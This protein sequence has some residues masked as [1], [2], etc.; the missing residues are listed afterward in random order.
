MEPRARPHNTT[1]LI[2]ALAGLAV[3]ALFYTAAAQGPAGAGIPGVAIAAG[4]GIATAIAL[5]LRAIRRTVVEPLRAQLAAREMEVARLTAALKIEAAAPLAPRP[6]FIDD[7]LARLTPVGGAQGRRKLASLTFVVF[8][9]ET[10]G[11]DTR[12]DEIVSVGAVRTQGAKSL[13]GQCFAT[14]VDPGRPIPKTSTAIHGIDDAAVAGAPSPAKAAR[15][16]AAF[17][18][19][20]VLVAHNAAFDLAFLKRAGHAAGIEFDH[21]PFDTL[22]IARHLFPDLAD[23]SLDGL[24]ALLGIEIG[25]RHSALDDA[26]ATA[27]IFARLLDVC[28]LRGIDDYDELVEASNMALELRRA[29]RSIA[30]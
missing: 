20:A 22:L 24:A 23:H 3:A 7:D 8:D 10:T 6:E 30:R 16:F 2:A 12:N 26:N 9:L 4:L 21:P 5:V 27:R 29:A 15:R 11:L 1:L 14:L 28:A 19:G 25:R 17:A 18:H 13:D